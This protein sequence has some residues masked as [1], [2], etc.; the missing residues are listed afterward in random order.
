MPISI[1]RLVTDEMPYLPMVKAMA[2]KAPMGAAFIS[3]ATSLK[4]GYIRACMKSVTGLPFSPTIPSA[5]PKRTE[6]NSTCR[7]SPLAK[8]PTMVVGM[9]FIRKPVMVCS[10][11]LSA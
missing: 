4:I 1:A 6:K 5:M 11:A 10:W 9:M 7:M 8:A 3:I 2:P